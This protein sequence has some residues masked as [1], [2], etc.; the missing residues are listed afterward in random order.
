MS[1]HYNASMAEPSVNEILEFALA[2]FP[3]RPAEFILPRWK[4]VAVDHKPDGSEV[5]EAD[6]GAEQLLRQRIAARY[7]GHAILG[8]E[9]GGDRL[10]DA[11]HLWVLDPIDGTASFAIG[12]LTFTRNP[13]RLPARRQSVRRR[14][15]RARSW[16]DRL[17]S[18][19]PGL[20]APTRRS[21][22][23]ASPDLRGHRAG[24]RL[25]GVDRAR[26]HRSRPARSQSLSRTLTSLPP[27]APLP[28]VGR[29]HQLH[30]LVRGTHRRRHRSAHEPTGHRPAVAPC[31]R[32]AG[33]V[34]T[35]L[36]GNPDVVWQPNLVASA[37]PALHEKVLQLLSN[38]GMV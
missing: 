14:D 29:L 30:A 1:D 21:G 3:V 5:T 2:R 10:R 38:R 19:R 18:G 28:L 25:R 34:L 16:R 32:E 8:E 37:T 26:T 31:V 13:D 7:P 23:H 15:R 22:P 6:R 17:R 36:D 35:S 4:N 9:F 27:R 20:L 11:E 24:R 12:L 33:G